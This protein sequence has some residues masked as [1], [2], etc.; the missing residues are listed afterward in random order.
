MKKEKTYQVLE[1]NTIRRR[2]GHLELTKSTTLSNDKYEDY[3]KS[4]PYDFISLYYHWKITGKTPVIDDNIIVNEIMHDLNIQEKYKDIWIDGESLRAAW[5]QTL[6]RKAELKKIIPNCAERIS[7]LKELFSKNESGLYTF[8][9]W[10]NDLRA[11]KY[12][13]KE[14]DA[15]IIIG[16]PGTG[17]THYTIDQIAG[18]ST[19][20]V[21]LSNL[22]G[23]NFVSRF[24]KSGK[25]GSCEFASYTKVRFMDISRHYD[26]V[27]FEEASML[28][29]N[30]LPLIIKCLHNCDNVFFCGDTNQLPSFLGF[31]NI[32]Y[33]LITEFPNKV[34]ELKNNHRCSQ[35]VVNGM[36]SILNG[37]FP[38]I[39]SANQFKALLDNALAND[40]NM[41]IPAFENKTVH[42]WN[43][44]CLQ[45]LAGTTENCMENILTVK[46]KKIPVRATQNIKVQKSDGTYEYKFYNNELCDVTKEGKDYVVQ[47]RLYPSHRKSYNSLDFITNDEYQPR[48]FA[49]AYSITVHKSQG[50]E[51]DEVFF[52]NDANDFLR[53]RNLC[54]VAY[55]RSRN[56]TYIYS[57]TTSTGKSITYNNIFR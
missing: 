40:A 48:D 28:S 4:K 39:Y 2:N 34:I 44:Y 8:T 54:Y 42:D 18:K 15:K 35:A 6:A 53:N 57:S 46:Q 5:N 30:E 36:S 24:N 23:A 33:G 10:K 52:M 56:N 29:T 27:V 31:G 22:V 32:L 21:T 47:S 55:T 16:K 7:P 9:E 50:L 3:S 11:L 37:K 13:I 17:K 38:Q 45:T 49:L 19:L 20:V 25:D 14:R 41:I 51:W 1:F 26:N 12:W 43:T